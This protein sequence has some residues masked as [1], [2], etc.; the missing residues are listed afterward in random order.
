MSASYE[1]LETLQAD[2][3]SVLLATP[4]LANCAIISDANGDTNS[5]VTKALSGTVKNRANKYGLALIVLCPEVTESEA[6]LPGPT[7]LVRVDVQVL[8]HVQT[9]R[10]ANGT[11]L[12]SSHAAM[13]ALNTLHLRA[14]GPHVL[15]AEKRPVEPLPA[16]EGFVSHSITLFLQAGLEALDKP[17]AV[18]A[19]MEHT[20]TVSGS[21][22]PD[23]SGTLIPAGKTGP[24]DCWSSTGLQTV[25]SY[26]YRFLSYDPDEF[27]FVLARASSYG[28]GVQWSAPALLGPYTPNP[29]GGGSGTA[30]VSI[31]SSAVVLTC[32]SASS[33]IRY[34]TDGSYPSPTKTLYTTPLTGLSVGTVVR[35]AAYVAGMP[36]GDVLEFTIKD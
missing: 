35:A 15:Y 22:T 32:A 11:G 26:P 3:V 30:T 18:Q 29:L 36:P 12:R 19:V 13:I 33:S 31:L 9:N 4:A 25:S 28:V 24:D 1:L 2:I 23:V 34:T 6:N 5:A 17:Q 10:A 16:N 14:M 8:E 21:L 20:L 7:L 27:V